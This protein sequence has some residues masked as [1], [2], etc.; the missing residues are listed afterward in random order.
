MPDVDPD[1]PGSTLVTV[2]EAI[3]DTK[4]EIFVGISTRFMNDIETR[5]R[6]RQELAHW[7]STDRTRVQAIEYG[8]PYD[9]ARD[10]LARYEHAKANAGW[11][12]LSLPSL[13]DRPIAQ[14]RSRSGA[15]SFG[16]GA[17]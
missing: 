17:R 7:K 4:R 11:K 10:F 16:R 1:T 8:M 5:L 3:N 15:G 6:A 2:Y 12:V 14:S 9:A 13:D